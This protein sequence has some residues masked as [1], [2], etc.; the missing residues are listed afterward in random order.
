ML[1]SDSDLE[2]FILVLEFRFG[3]IYPSFGMESIIPIQLFGSV[4]WMHIITIVDIW[5]I[6]SFEIEYKKFS[7]IKCISKF[8]ITN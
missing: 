3:I 7:L 1:E 6:D 8:S 5:F 2:S 4:P